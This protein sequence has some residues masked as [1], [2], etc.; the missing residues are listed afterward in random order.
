MSR[1]KPAPPARSPA[2]IST[3]SAEVAHNVAGLKTVLV[4]VVRSSTRM[5]TAAAS[6]ATDPPPARVT[7]GAQQLQLT[8]ENCSAD[9]VLLTG[10]TGVLQPNCRVKVTI[11]GFATPLGGNIV[12]AG[13]NSAS[14]KFD[15]TS[16]VARAL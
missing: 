3:I 14:V 6:R 16:T 5:S 9:G 12:A 11:D 4:R 8:A 13:H 10:D 2:D 15:L 1:R 7:M